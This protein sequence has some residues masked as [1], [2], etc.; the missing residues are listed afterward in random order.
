MLHHR[1][2]NVLLLQMCGTKNLPNFP[3]RKPENMSPAGT[4]E[5]N[6]QRNLDSHCKFL[7]FHVNLHQGAKR[8]KLAVKAGQSRLNGAPHI[9]AGNHLTGHGWL[10]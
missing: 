2:F 6:R 4:V 7:L 8:R 3:G 9:S 10:L 1:W 5:R